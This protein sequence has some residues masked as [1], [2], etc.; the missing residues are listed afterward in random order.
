MSVDLPI[1]VAAPALVTSPLAGEGMPCTARIRHTIFLK[2]IFSSVIWYK[3]LM[4]S[5]KYEVISLAIKFHIAYKVSMTAQS[6]ICA[7]PLVHVENLRL[8]SEPVQRKDR[9]FI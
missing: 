2:F 5:W 3:N 9:P 8:L 7:A 4:F 6:F 1:T